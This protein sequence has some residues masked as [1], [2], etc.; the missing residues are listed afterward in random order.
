[1]GMALQSAFLMVVLIGSPSLLACSIR[2]EVVNSQGEGV[3]FQVI[4]LH[5]RIRNADVGPLPPA[6]KSPVTI[7]LPCSYYEY[8]V[9]IDPGQR[10]GFVSAGTVEVDS[11]DISVYRV[12]NPRRVVGANGQVYSVSRGLSTRRSLEGRLLGPIAADQPVRIQLLSLNGT[13]EVEVVADAK[14]YFWTN[15]QLLGVH[16]FLVFVGTRLAHTQAIS[17][18]Y[19]K[20]VEV[21]IPL[22]REQ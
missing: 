17:F 10:D 16:T 9:R 4:H 1:M 5:D 13:V 22:F 21:T 12:H 7:P 8:E 6:G 3:P 20:L 14:G 18:L 11:N 19:G 15:R 2:V